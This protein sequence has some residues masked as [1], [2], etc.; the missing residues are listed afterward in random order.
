MPS[1]LSSYLCRTAGRLKDELIFDTTFQVPSLDHQF[2]GV[3]KYKHYVGVYLPHAKALAGQSLLP[4]FNSIIFS[5]PSMADFGWDLIPGEAYIIRGSVAHQPNGVPLWTFNPLTAKLLLNHPFQ[6]GGAV[7]AVT[8]RGTLAEAQHI[9]ESN[10]GDVG[11][12][13]SLI[14]VDALDD[15]V[16]LDVRFRNQLS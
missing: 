3:N 11:D 9:P 4:R 5:A 14:G 6:G 1:A 15:T 8:G 16:I 10:Y 13:R 7:V 12:S 2:G